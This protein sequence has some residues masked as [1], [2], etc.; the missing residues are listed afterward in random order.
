MTHKSESLQLT[1]AGQIEAAISDTVDMPAK[2]EACITYQEYEK[3][4]SNPVSSI[5]TQMPLNPNRRKN[6]SPQSTLLTFYLP[7]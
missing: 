1:F 2:L 6:K 3:P 5:K 4:N 7:E